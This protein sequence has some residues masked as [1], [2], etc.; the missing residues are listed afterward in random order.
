VRT[1]R[2]PIPDKYYAPAN[3]L[4]PASVH[5]PGFVVGQRLALLKAGLMYGK[6]L[7]LR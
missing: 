3:C 6:T 7:G 2:R 1:S 5:L 4:L